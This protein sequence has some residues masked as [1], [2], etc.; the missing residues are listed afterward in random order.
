MFEFAADGDEA[1]RTCHVGCRHPSIEKSA[2]DPRCPPAATH[3]AASGARPRMPPDPHNGQEGP[4]PSVHFAKDSFVQWM[5]DILHQL[6]GGLSDY[7]QGFNHPRWC[8][9]YSIYIPLNIHRSFSCCLGGRRNAAAPADGVGGQ[10]LGI[11]QAAE[12]HGLFLKGFNVPIIKPTHLYIIYIYNLY[13]YTIHIYH[14]DVI[15]TFL[16]RVWGMIWRV[17]HTL[18]DSV[19]IHKG[20]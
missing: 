2:A 15:S 9:I 12:F 13:I 1:M 19:W 5:E 8:R 7:S 3:E 10:D 20:G 4:N 6:I 14:M 11:G 17:S 18:S 16:G